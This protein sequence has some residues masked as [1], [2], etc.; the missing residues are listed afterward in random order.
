MWMMRDHPWLYAESCIKMTTAIYQHCRH[1]QAMS[2]FASAADKNAEIRASVQADGYDV[3]F[4]DWLRTAHP[5][6]YKEHVSDM[7]QISA[8]NPGM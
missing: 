3:A 6:V 5:D 8:K 2:E 4:V 7:A 1:T